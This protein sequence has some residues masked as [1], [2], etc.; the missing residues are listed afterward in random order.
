MCEFESQKYTH[1]LVVTC[2]LCKSQNIRS[3]SLDYY[4]CEICKVIFRKIMPTRE[5]IDQI[6]T[7][8][9]TPEN[10]IR[11]ITQMKS[12]EISL[13]KHAEYIQTIVEPPAR[14]LDLG[15][16]TGEFVKILR[17]K[18]YDV[19]GCELSPEA[20]RMAKKKFG[21]DFYSSLDQIEDVYDLVTGIEVVEHLVNP[22]NILDKV[23]QVLGPGGI[24]YLSTPNS[25]GL[26]AKLSREKWR[27]A[28]RPFH[29]VLF[30]YSSMKQLVEAT[31][32]PIMEHIRFNPLVTESAFTSIFHR[33][34][35]ILG[36][37]G[38]LLVICR[39]K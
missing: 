21:F 31:G 4:K 16:S 33:G 11:N 1:N 36:L 12:G 15:A 37:Y 17:D 19:S 8:Y 20:R 34:L 39:K 22:L 38:G 5:E 27:E 14:I 23:Y 13:N 2:L 3:W 24:A 35:Q 32:F 7:Q 28:V 29:L 18:G 25:D 30:N 9:Y 6:Y 26:N 10:I